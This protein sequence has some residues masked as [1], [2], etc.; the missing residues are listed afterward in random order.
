MRWRAPILKWC[1]HLGQTLRLASRS[2]LK[3]TA[4][5]PTHLIHKPSVRT[6]FRSASAVPSGAMLAP[7]SFSSRLNQDIQTL[8]R[9]GLGIAKMKGRWEILPVNFLA[10]SIFYAALRPDAFLHC[11]PPGRENM[12]GTL[13]FVSSLREDRGD[14]A[15]TASERTSF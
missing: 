2:A 13:S 14:W 3:M 6:V 15:S 12:L 10:A 11:A 9:T 5:Q 1:W 8:S 7:Y 4:R